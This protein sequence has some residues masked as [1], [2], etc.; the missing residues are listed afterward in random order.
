VVPG[1]FSGKSTVGPVV[2]MQNERAHPSTKFLS[3]RSSCDILV[4]IRQSVRGA[5]WAWAP[6]GTREMAFCPKGSSPALF[7]DKHLFVFFLP[8]SLL[9]FFL[10]KKRTNFLV[11]PSSTFYYSIIIMLCLFLLPRS[12]LNCRSFQKKIEAS[13]NYCNTKYSLRL[14]INTQD[15]SLLE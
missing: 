13:I 6:R 15:T 10:K 2:D 3:L 9:F 11:H 1:L 4:A 8:S 12:K 5:R 7:V 14:K